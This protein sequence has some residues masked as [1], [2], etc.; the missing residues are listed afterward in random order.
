MSILAYYSLR[1]A[2]KG[3]K[4]S[5]KIDLFEAQ[6]HLEIISFGRSKNKVGNTALN[7]LVLWYSSLPWS[8]APMA[9]V[10]PMTSSRK[11]AAIYITIT[12]F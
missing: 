8:T 9:S 6:L 10:R 11:C 2:Q 1:H 12:N 3:Q 7:S 5:V 4:R